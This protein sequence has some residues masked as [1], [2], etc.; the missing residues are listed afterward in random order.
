MSTTWSVLDGAALNAFEGLP[1][2]V[3]AEGTLLVP[4]DEP[5]G[6][7]C[8]VGALPDALVVPV[9]ACCVAEPLPCAAW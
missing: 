6:F 7:V 3:L 1:V 2:P 9:L 8:C 5:V 4:V